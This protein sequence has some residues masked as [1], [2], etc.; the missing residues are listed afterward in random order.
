MSSPRQLNEDMECIADSLTA[1][2]TQVT[3]LAAVTLQNRWA[4][5]LLT[6][7]KGGTCLYL[8]KEC[9]YFVNQSGIVTSKVK[10]L[11]DRIRARCQDDSIWDLNP[12]AWVT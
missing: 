10:E 8:N 1:L 2:Q 4:L 6:A 7:E 5:D 3:S 11:R 12:Q 9:Y